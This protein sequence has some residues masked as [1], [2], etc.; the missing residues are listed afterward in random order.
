[1][2]LRLTFSECTEIAGIMALCYLTG[3]WDR[4]WD[5]GFLIGTEEL[6][7]FLMHTGYPADHCIIPGRK[8]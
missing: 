3:A 8:E 4:V 2:L 1:M 7:V 5:A 6:W